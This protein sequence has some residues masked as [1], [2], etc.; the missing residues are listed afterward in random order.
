MP[1]AITCPE[2][3]KQGKVPDSYAGRKAVCP[4]CKINV[5]VPASRP[6]L[7]NGSP[8]G[9]PR[10]ATRS[11]AASRSRPA[12]VPEVMDPP[13]PAPPMPLARWPYDA[14]PEIDIPEPPQHNRRRGG[15]PLPAHSHAQQPVYAP[16]TQAV[17]AL[18]QKNVGIAILLAIF[19]GPVGMLYSTILGA[20]VM[21]LPC[22][23]IGL[24]T[25]GFGWI[26]TIPICALWAAIAASRYNQ[27]LLR[28]AA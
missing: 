28:G 20:V 10:V 25:F 12:E 5:P 17:V 6:K 18:S 8:A 19:F 2:C 15:S 11:S 13:V 21:F 16:R 1:I 27:K 22:L 4:A 23:L 7:G 14:D 9:V 26:L 24:L 3:G